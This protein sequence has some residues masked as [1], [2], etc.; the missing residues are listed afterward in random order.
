MAVCW[1]LRLVDVEMVALRKILR[2][3]DPGV[4]PGMVSGLYASE[5]HER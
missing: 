2:A 5:E 3:E 4:C 1:R